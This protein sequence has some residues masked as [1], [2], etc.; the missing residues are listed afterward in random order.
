MKITNQ[1]NEELKQIAMD[2]YQG[3]I[4]TDRHLSKSEDAFLVFTVLSLGGFS[5]FSDEDLEDIGLM[6]EYLDKAGPRSINGYPMFLSLRLL[7]Q[8]DTKIVFDF[9]KKIKESFKEIS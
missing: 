7:N 4:F 8:H 9:Y 3:K 6:F 1:T 5:E 2:L